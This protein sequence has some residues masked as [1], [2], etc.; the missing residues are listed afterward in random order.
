MSFRRKILWAMLAV[1]VAGL[2]AGLSAQPIFE[3][4]TPTGFSVSD[5]IATVNF[6]NDTPVT[7]QVDLNE[8]V[9]A[10]YPVIG[11]FQKLET[12]VP[13]FTS[14]QSQWY[15][16]QSLEVDVN[17]ILHRAWIQNRGIAD[18]T[19]PTSTPIY[20]VVYAKS[21][22]G[23][24]SWLDTVSVSGT[25]TFDL[26]TPSGPSV[27]SGYSTLDLVV[28]S[29]GNPRVVYSMDWSGDGSSSGVATRQFAS[30]G[31]RAHRN[32]LFNYSND[33]G[34]SWLP[35]NSAVVINDTT[36]LVDAGGS[37][38]VLA[39]VQAGRNCAFPRMAITSTDDIFIVYEREYLAANASDI[40]LSKMDADSLKLGSAQPVTVGEAGTVGSVGGVAICDRGTDDI[41]TGPDIAVGD[42]DVLHIVWFNNTDDEVQHKQLQ[43]DLW[44]D[45]STF[46][47]DQTVPG[48]TVGSFV[49]ATAPLGAFGADDIH[50]FPTVAID[51]ARTPD[52]VYALWKHGDGAAVDENIAYNTSNYGGVSGAGAAW[53]TTPSYAFDQSAVTLGA[54]T[55]DPLFLT[56]SKYLIQ[57]NNWGYVDRVAAAFDTRK[58]TSGDLHVVFSAGESMTVA[59]GAISSVANRRAN[60]LYYTRFNGVEWELPQVVA[61]GLNAQADGVVSAYQ[62]VF[63]PDIGLRDG[64]DNVYLS[65]VGGSSIDSDAPRGL[66]AGAAL[67]VNGYAAF[68]K[69][70]GRVV[71]FEDMSIPSGAYVYRMEYSPVNAQATATHN[72]VSVTA[73]GNSDGTGIGAA[74]PPT[75]A[76]AGGFL[77]GRWVHLTASSLGVS[78]LTPGT[79]NAVFKGA[80][81]QQEAQNNT[82]VWEGL[83]N[84]GGSSGYAEW[85]DNG[86]KIGLLVK[87]NVL[88]ADS[89]T[90]NLFVITAFTA[91][92]GTTQA[93]VAYAGQSISVQGY[94]VDSQVANW[95]VNGDGV[96]ET[97]VPRGSFFQLGA[98]ITILADNK[99]PVVQ[100]VTPDAST[101]G[102]ANES[103]GIR[104]VIYDEDDNIEGTGADTLKMELYAYPDRALSTV[105]DIR[106]FGTLIVDENDALST[107]AP[108][109]TGD[110]TEG[111]SSSIVLTYTWDDPGVTLQNAYNWAPITKTRDGFYYIY[112]VADDGSN[113]PVFDVSDASVWI[114][115][116]PLVKSI[117]PIK[118][119]TVDT[120]EYDDLD[121]TNPYKVKFQ[122]VDYDD[123]AQ[124]RL[125]YATSADLSASDVDTTSGTLDLAGAT[126]IQLSDTL[127]TDDDI[128]F[129]FDVT[130]QGTTRDS[131]IAQGSYYIYAVVAD[132]D[133]FAVGKST[134]QLAVRHSPAFEFTAPLLGSVRK[135]NTTQQFAYTIEWQRGRSDQ[136]LDGNA[137]ISLYYTGVDPVS[138]D[139]SGIDSTSL[140]STAA[141]G[142]SAVLITG[143][144]REDDEGAND[145]YVWDFKTPPGVLPRVYRPDHSSGAYS[146]HS[147]QTGAT[148]DTAWIYAVLHDTLGNTRVEAG[149]AVLLLGS[150]ENPASQTPRVVM[151]TPVAG[152]ALVIN[153]DVVKLEWD[154]FLIDDGTGTDDAYLRLYAAP[155]NKYTTLTELEGNMVDVAGA[156][157]VILINSL[158]GSDAN[159][160]AEIVLRESSPKFYKWDTKTTSFRIT[161]TPT[162]LDIFIAAS[163]DPFRTHGAKPVY[164]NGVLDSIASGYGSESMKAVL[165]RAPGVL[166]VEGFDPIYSIE[167]SP[168]SFSASSG[169]TLD[170][171]LFINSQGN[172]VDLLAL[173]LNVPRNYFDVV[174]QD[175]VTAGVQPFVDSTAAFQ[176]PS[177]IVQNDTTQGDEQWLK[178]N[179]VEWSALGEVIG[180]VATPFDS[181]QVAGRVK[182]VVKQYSGG[183]PLDTVLQWSSE[184]GRQTGLYR[185]TTK[186]AQPA[187]DGQVVLTP[188]ARLLVTV[189]L[190]GRGGAYAD[191]LDVHLREIGST[192]DITDQSYIRANDVDTVVT[193]TVAGTLEDSVQVVSDVFGTFALTEIP[194]G[195][196]EVTVKAPGYV[197]GRSDTL[198]LFNGSM[199]AIEPTFGSDALGNLSPATALGFLRGGDASNDNQV[200]ISD[201]NLI[202]SVWN[203]VR[204]DSLYVRDADVNNDGVINSLDLGFVTKNF[205]NDGFGAPPVFKGITEGGDN[206]GAIVKVTG[207]EEVDA[208]WPGR[209]FEVSARIEGMSDVAAYGLRLTYDPERVVP[210]AGDQAVEQGDIFDENP[211]GSLFFHRVLPGAVDVG[212]G[213]I[214]ADWSAS[215][216]ASLVTVR[217]MALGD[218]PGVI[219]IAGGELGNSAHM[220]VLLRVETAQALPKVV[221]LH[222]NYPNPFN[223]STEIRF[224]VPTARDVQLRI[225]NQ[226]GQTVRTLVDQRMK[227]G[228]HALQWDGADEMGQAVASGVY[229]Y[230]LEA[231]DFSQIRKMTLLK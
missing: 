220:G 5:S 201:A 84:D 120:G 54:G 109:G 164:V 175:T 95:P 111:T 115:H 199:Q 127:T 112:G 123:N 46:G 105:R 223:P 178:L 86:D 168:G 141:S 222:Q 28:D 4:A 173:H 134:V 145:Q 102:F 194:S 130:A 18:P 44:T 150:G 161:G 10:A 48:A 158:T 193:D 32:I 41:G 142:G 129:D 24:E 59:G 147:Y 169:D 94:T 108:A 213:R 156:K 63:D 20:G 216:D 153:G 80:L 82:G 30:T 215:G 185:G 19:T 131:V 51:R 204:D 166:R 37:A 90:N 160:D 15:M 171:D 174:D 103:F 151:R 57:S 31:R 38:S 128:E 92:A 2:G 81:S 75:S 66:A 21:V 113:P 207:I 67:S 107:A 184:S 72:L 196:F 231:G 187:R 140:L 42:G 70:L 99:A 179:F 122:L 7:I 214:G 218:D 136:D 98:N 8:P 119:D 206:A 200:D 65:F 138:T 183:A 186:L 139:F 100:V 74:T 191:T 3:N 163:M 227:A 76:A 36:S 159:A 50:L 202:F 47:W 177:T 27:L 83:V 91:A 96:D 43:D 189:A 6:V 137:I 205:G 121:K 135:V 195:V 132:G 79:N 71:T 22:N 155:K 40:M 58:V 118:A 85:G 14:K 224:D 69:V 152:N 23:G 182:L 88:G 170:L 209:V 188:R 101:S 229:F 49:E 53:G 212:A 172:S 219:D 157:D 52:R 211:A 210:L 87:L 226:L 203:K 114:R 61:S 190:E 148:V 181:S 217:F 125:F 73:A 106:T 221:A 165:S 33:G 16:A 149:G 89:P 133:T 25:M 124:V 97:V 154:A 116:V 197:T 198:T 208:W 176:T 11:N 64:D 230:N 55:G 110:F 26:I 60:G 228:A 77:T 35:A 17:G 162:E 144:I 56:D 9:N 117:T 39:T 45:V 167:L 126:P 104:Y 146:V 78:T 62:M 93:G 143:G 180:R 68:F 12:S 225:Y 34:S 13:F 192:H 1:L 29:K